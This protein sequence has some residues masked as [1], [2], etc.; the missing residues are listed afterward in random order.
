MGRTLEGDQIRPPIALDEPNVPVFATF[1]VPGSIDT[2]AHGVILSRGFTDYVVWDVHLSDEGR[3]ED[4][5]TWH[6][7]NGGYCAMTAEGWVEAEQLFGKRV[8]R[9]MSAAM[10]TGGLL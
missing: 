10:R 5:P 7:S 6:R 4:N 9:L 1:L 8:A 2:Y 3:F